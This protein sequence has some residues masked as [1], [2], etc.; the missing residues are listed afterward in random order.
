[1]GEEGSDHDHSQAMHSDGVTAR[2]A[3]GRKTRERKASFVDRM[4]GEAKALIGRKNVEGGGGTKAKHGR[5][6]SVGESSVPAAP[7]DVV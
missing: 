5:K 4:L 3:H 6:S 7:A 1:M 2:D